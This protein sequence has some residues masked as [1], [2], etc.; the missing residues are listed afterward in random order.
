MRRASLL[1]AIV[2]IIVGFALGYG[3]SRIDVSR[4]LS[5]SA[6]PVNTPS[7]VG[8][9]I[10]IVPPPPPNVE[11][12]APEPPPVE[13]I[14][15]TE[16]AK[17]G[18]EQTVSRPVAYFPPP[19]TDL[20][21]S[22]L[23]TQRVPGTADIGDVYQV[24][25]HDVSQALYM[26]VIEP[27]RLRSIWR[28]AEDGAVE[29]VFAANTAPGEIR[30][31]GDGKGVMYVL[32]DNPTRV[33][34]TADAFKTWHTVIENQ[35]LFWQIAHDG[36]KTV[37]GSLHGYNSAWLY[38][39]PDDGFSWEPW[40][41]FQ[42]VLPADAVQYDPNDPRLRLRHLHGVIYND[43][44]DLLLVGTGDV[45]RYTL[46]SRDDGR[47]WKKVWDEG[48]TAWVQMSGGNRYLLC[49]DRL[50]GPGI[51]LYDIWA[52]TV[53]EVWNPKPYNYAGYCYSI[54]NVD[55]IYYAAFHT[56][57]NEVEEVVPKSGIIVSPDG[58][59]WYPFLEWDPLSRHART[60]I[61]LAAAPGR[62]YASLNGA[63]Y[64]F[65]PL[66]DDWFASRQPFK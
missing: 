56:E 13:E 43:K 23:G 55:A 7:P 46:E 16:E 41:D 30:I 28:V 50:R 3:A 52:G 18:S 5:P 59:A 40:I 6:P 26:A 32:H 58:E 11:L 34:R 37:Y 44:S 9:Q 14:A 60:N 4:L 36:R 62:V 53:K 20:T 35:E 15:K 22:K 66:A 21:G 57:A 12:A 39:S 49:P 24:Y 25:W 8:S 54:I 64:A 65:K 48:F 19:S 63:L 38:R 47:T 61:W 17:Q 27:S 1:V 10:I 51:A 29:R 31:M 42:K 33:Y 45:A 2:S